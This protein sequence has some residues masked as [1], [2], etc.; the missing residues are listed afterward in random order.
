MSGA[1]TPFVW[2]AAGPGGL[3]ARFQ[4]VLAASS[5]L[6]LRLFGEEFMAQ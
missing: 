5:R 4:L 3:N 6:Q 2:L 1:R